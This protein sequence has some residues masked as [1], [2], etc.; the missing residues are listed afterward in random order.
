MQGL[1]FFY[2]KV[3][4]RHLIIEINATWDNSPIFILEAACRLQ[5]EAHRHLLIR[6]VA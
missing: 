6:D 5:R 2:L 3:E 4:Q 1:F